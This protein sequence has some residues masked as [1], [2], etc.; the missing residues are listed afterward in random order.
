M[1]SHPVYMWHHIP[2]IY[3]IISTKYDI[4]TLCVGD[5]T[6]GICVTSF[7]L[8][9]TSHTLYHPKPQNLWCH[10]HFR[11]DFTSHVSDTAPTLSLSSQPLHWYHTNFWITS[12]PLSVWHHMHY[13]YHHI[14]SLCHHTT[15]FMTSQPLYVKP[16]PVCRAT[17]TLYLRHHSH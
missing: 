2:Y 11:H 10:I 16:H 7:P 1:V 6:L 15:L 17:Y 5:T 13:I 12:H 3:E 14:Q 9:M 4:T 8:Q